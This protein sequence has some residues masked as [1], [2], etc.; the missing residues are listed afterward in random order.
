MDRELVKLI[1]TQGLHGTSTPTDLSFAD[2]STIKAIPGDTCTV[3]KN[4]A[5][6]PDLIY[7]ICCPKFFAMYP[8]NES[9]PQKCS[10]RH[11]PEKP[12]KASTG[13]NRLGQLEITYLTNFARIGN[14]RAALASGSF[15]KSFKPYVKQIRALYQ[16]IPFAAETATNRRQST[17]EV[18]MLNQLIDWLNQIFPLENGG[19]WTTSSKWSMSLASVN[20]APVNS[21]IQIFPNLK[22]GNVVYS[23]MKTNESN[24]VVE[25]KPGSQ[26]KYGMIK[27][28]FTHL[29]RAPGSKAVKDTWLAVHPLVTIRCN[30][31]PFAQLQQYD[32]VGVALRKVE[33]DQEHIVL[34]EEVLAQCAWMTY[35][36]KELV[37][38][39]DFETIA[40]VSLDC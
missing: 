12:P 2:N 37:P 24:C 30:P 31:N 27:T 40:V 29:R 32:A 22:Q 13:N 14:L 25:L 33:Y 35:K 11:L 8:D 3:L 5:I 17:L 23:S 9:A 36:P 19:Q 20:K 10:F 15:P 6:E 26:T 21:L 38:A 16:P 39:I 28:I 34:L 18:G 7:C 4:L 1:V